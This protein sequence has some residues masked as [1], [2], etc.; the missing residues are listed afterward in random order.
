MGF[1]TFLTALFR[2]SW[3]SHRALY[4]KHEKV[5]VNNV[6]A[7]YRAMMLSFQPSDSYWRAHWL[8]FL[9]KWPSCR[10][11]LLKKS[12]TACF[13]FTSYCFVWNLYLVPFLSKQISAETEMELYRPFRAL[14]YVCVPVMGTKKVIPALRWQI[15]FYFFS[16]WITD[17]SGDGKNLSFLNLCAKWTDN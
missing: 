15:Y 12:F 2:R 17:R 9:P 8:T 4:R 10:K 14:Y 13:I 3:K 7:H 6:N 5:P 11:M 1:S 16:T